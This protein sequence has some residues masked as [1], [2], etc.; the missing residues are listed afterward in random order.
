MNLNILIKITKLN[1]I[2][3]ITILH[4][5]HPKSLFN[6]SISSHLLDPPHLINF[7]ILLLIENKDIFVFIIMKIVE[8]AQIITIFIK[9]LHNN[10]QILCKNHKMYVFKIFNSLKIH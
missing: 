4:P 3:S 9:F 8:C 6:N 2:L 10:L 5:Q 1:Q 7:E